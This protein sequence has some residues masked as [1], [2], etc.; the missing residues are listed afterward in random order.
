MKIL[1]LSQYYA[2]DLSAG[3]FRMNSF[4][5]NFT[6]LYPDIE[7]ELLTTMPNRYKSF[8]EDA[9]AIEKINNLTIHRF[10]LKT[11]NGG[12]KEQVLSYLGYYLNVLKMTKNKEYDLIFATSSRLFTATLGTYISWRKKIPLFLDIRDIFVDSISDVLKGFS[13]YL[14]IPPLKYIEKL[15]IKRAS[16]VNLVSKGFY[17]YFRD[18]YPLSNFSFI[19]NGIDDVFLNFDQTNTKNIKQKTILY[20]G[21][22]GEGQGLEKI[23][24]SIAKSLEHNYLIK[25]IGDGGRRRVLEENLLKDKITNVEI[26]DPIERSKLIQE[27]NNADI[28]FLHL[29]SYDAFKKVL[30]SKIFEYAATGKPIWAGVDGYAKEFLN[31]EVIN[32]AVFSPCDSIAALESLKKLQ[33]DNIDREAFKEK[34]SRNK[35]MK[36]LSIELVSVLS[37]SA[38]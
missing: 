14:I 19:S 8:H 23:I 26:I 18:R 15:T 36:E 29:N 30:P 6:E 20:A 37:K 1:I 34:F 33:L 31:E 35:L 16:K 7:I 11:H 2:P 17:S 12:M 24:P 4:V 22:I 38:P 9:K 28:L 13:K 27:Y 3:S 5:K 10:R 25:I 32:S 21:N